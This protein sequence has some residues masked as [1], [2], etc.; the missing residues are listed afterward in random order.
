MKS[1]K[2]WRER[3]R[4]RE[5]E[6]RTTAELATVDRLRDRVESGLW[7][8]ESRGGREGRIGR[9]SGRRSKRMRKCSEWGGAGS[10]WGGVG[11][12]GGDE[13][14]RSSAS[15]SVGLG[16]PK[17]NIHNP[18]PDRQLVGFI[19]ANRTRPTVLL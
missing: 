15:I 6:R 9:R 12:G 8:L 13:N 14:Q 16:D 4:E 17:Y 18:K 5:R 3:E 2:L 1:S 11:F 19:L 7:R 10:G